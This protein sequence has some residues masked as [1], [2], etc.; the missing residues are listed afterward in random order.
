[1]LVSSNVSIFYKSIPTAKIWHIGVNTR[2]GIKAV[3]DEVGS[4]NIIALT[5]NNAANMKAAWQEVKKEYPSVITL[6]CRSYMI[7]LLLGVSS[8]NYTLK[9]VYINNNIGNNGDSNNEV[10]FRANKEYIALF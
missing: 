1:M 8:L 3:I 9:I 5:T 2:A 7:S 4:S 10:L 6:G